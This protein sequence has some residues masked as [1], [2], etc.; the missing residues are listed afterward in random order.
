MAIGAVGF[1]IHV[2]L[3]RKPRSRLCILGFLGVALWVT[4]F[5]VLSWLG[6]RRSRM[7]H[8]TLSFFG[9]V[10]GFRWLELLLGTGPKG[11]DLSLRNFVIYFASPA[12]VLFDGAGRLKA[13][14]DG[15]VSE[16]L[17][18]IAKHMLLGTIVL[19]I[20][21]A[22]SFAPFLESGADAATMPL[23]GFPQAEPAIYLQTL[24]IYCTLATAMLMHRLLLAFFGIDT[25]DSMQ[26]P[27]LLSVSLREFWGR[28][29]NLVVHRLMKRTFFVPLAGSSAWSRRAAGLLAFAP[30]EPTPQLPPPAHGRVLPKMPCATPLLH[31]GFHDRSS[32]L[33]PRRR[34]T[35]VGSRR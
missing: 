1:Q 24:Y 5:L 35:E 21:K 7:A 34:R 20:G 16:L 2:A 32:P 29:W 17:F 31:Y 4:P 3:R 12:E 27:L 23:L 11:F 30:P 9:V 26:T 13:S 10:A 28:R 33:R 25:V 8:F 15:L 18:R 19:S 22:T 6:P 14:P